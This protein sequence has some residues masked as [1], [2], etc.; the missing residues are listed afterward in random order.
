V[1]DDIFKGFKAPEPTG[2]PGPWDKNSLAVVANS[3]AGNGGVILWTAGPHL[4]NEIDSIGSVRLDDLGLDDAP[5]GISIWE[6]KYIGYKTGNPMDGEEWDTEA[7][8]K[9]R[10]PTD[11]EWEAIRADR[12]PW[13]D[14]DWYSA[15]KPSDVPSSIPVAKPMEWDL[16]PTTCTPDDLP[17]VDDGPDCS[18][19][20]HVGS[21]RHAPRE[22][23]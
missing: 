11:A 3:S 13:P 12:C 4:E 2:V 23:K 8:G 6:G 22:T 19:G 16:C 7:H 14:S 17:D 15:V 18:G 10:T 9:F 20:V 1:T 5:E 21:C